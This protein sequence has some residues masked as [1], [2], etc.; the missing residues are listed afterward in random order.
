LVPESTSP[1]DHRF[2]EAEIFVKATVDRSGATPTLHWVPF[3]D[4]VDFE[5]TTNCKVATPPAGAADQPGLPV[6]G[7]KE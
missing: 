6:A 7:Q 1:T 2:V 3:G 5:S 4:M